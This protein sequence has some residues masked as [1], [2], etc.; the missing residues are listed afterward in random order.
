[1]KAPRSLSLALSLLV[2]LVRCAE[3]EPAKGDEICQEAG[4]SIANR[5]LACTSDQDL[6][7]ARYERLRGE[8]DCKA[9]DPSSHTDT[10]V[11]C[12]RA[13][14]AVTCEQVATLGEDLDAWL[15]SDPK[16]QAMFA[17]KDGKSLE[18]PDPCLP[19]LSCN[20]ACIDINNDFNNCG[21]CGARCPS[22]TTVCIERE[23]NF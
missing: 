5:T 14:L 20:G 13:L 16:C 9:A 11:E 6:S 23:C 1:M 4:F 12:P 21:A 15:R 7:N 22:P 10:Q 17:R 8:Y 18:P 2:T 3:V 19:L